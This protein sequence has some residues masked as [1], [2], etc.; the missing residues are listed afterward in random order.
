[1]EAVSFPTDNLHILMFTEVTLSNIFL[2]HLHNLL[3]QN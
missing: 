1:M 2:I 3:Q